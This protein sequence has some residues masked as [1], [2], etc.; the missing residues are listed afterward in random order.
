[1]ARIKVA[2]Y[3]SDKQYRERFADYLMSYKAEEIELSVFSTVTYFLDALDV[4][5]YQLLVLGGGYEEVLP[6]LRRFAVPVMVLSDGGFVREGV[7]IEEVQVSYT[8]KY[9]SMDAITHQMYL[10]T[11][12]RSGARNI[13]QGLTAPEVIGVFSPVRHEMQMF[14]SL[15][16]A[17][18]KQSEGKVL[19]L[20]LME[21]SGF[22]ELFGMEDYDMEEVVLQ[23]RKPCIRPELIKGCIYER[24]EFSYICP[25][26][27]PENVK[28]FTA[29]DLEML[30]K[31]LTEETDFRTVIIDFGGVMEGFSEAMKCCSRIIS[32]G[33]QGSFCQALVE[34]FCNY[35]GNTL[36]EVFLERI[37]QIELPC[38]IKGMNASTS[39]L[40]Q[41]WWSEFGD[42]V[43]GV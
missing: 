23:I 9:Q 28:E 4:E 43:R 40:E 19:Y 7:D 30:L 17:Q 31:F 12:A 42:C 21:F 25:F 13:R 39:L 16:L 22:S 5:K 34:R 6:R 37:K 27:N 11:E 3:D 41:L 20:N 32:I 8:S 33:R 36:G 38:I 26:G 18:S 10:M 35:L 2:I 24:E 29:K 14:F 15:L 1:M